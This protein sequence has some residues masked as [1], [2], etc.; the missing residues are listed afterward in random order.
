MRMQG[1][2]Q[3]VAF[4]QRSLCLTQAG[5]GLTG[6]V[7]RQGLHKGAGQTKGEITAHHEAMVPACCRHPGR[8]QARGPLIQAGQGFQRQELDRMTRTHSLRQR[9]RLAP[10]GRA[11]EIQAQQ[12]GRNGA[13]FDRLTM[14]AVASNSS[15]RAIDT[16]PETA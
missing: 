5:E 8:L 13:Q 6:A 7:C 3:P 1:V 12:G 11:A 16:L 15:S 10:R 4:G 14:Q 2:D 9:Q